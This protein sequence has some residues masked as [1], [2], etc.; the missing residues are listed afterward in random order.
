MTSKKKKKEEF[1][2]KR[3]RNAFK[4]GIPREKQ[5]NKKTKKHKK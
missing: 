1:L 2:T 4:G 3:K 5:A